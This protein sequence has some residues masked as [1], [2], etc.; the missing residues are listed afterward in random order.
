MFRVNI[1]AGNHTGF[2]LSFT[3][4]PEY[5]VVNEDGKEVVYIRVILEEN[6]ACL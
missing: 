1:S 5:M 6:A 2:H 4:E 3:S